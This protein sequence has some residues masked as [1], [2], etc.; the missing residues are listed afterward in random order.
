MSNKIQSLSSLD[1]FVLAL[2]D[3]GV[4]TSYAMREQAGISV[5]ASRP[6]LQRLKKLGLVDEGQAGPRGKLPFTLTARGRRAR[7]AEFDRLVAEFRLKSPS[8]PESLMRIAAIAAFEGSTFLTRTLLKKAAEG[9]RR[10]VDEFNQVD[11][12]DDFSVAGRYRFMVALCTAAQHKAIS[13]LFEEMAG[14]PAS[15]RTERQRRPI[16]PMI[17]RSLRSR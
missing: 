6:A 17:R 3:S 2:I 4:A 14:L 8:E 13:T 16:K 10:L 9:N 5:G 1:V 7:V 15:T 12:E 11:M